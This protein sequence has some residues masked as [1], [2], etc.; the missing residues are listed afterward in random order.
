MEVLPA[1]ERIRQASADG[2]LAELCRSQGIELLVLFGSAVSSPTPG[3]IDLAV[4]FEPAG[5]GNLLD[6]V[7][8]LSE[9]FATDALD[10][11]D[12]D[13]AGPVARQRALT[14]GEILHQSSPRAF[15]ERHLWALA[16]YMET[17]G[18]RQLQ[19]EVLAGG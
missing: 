15:S 4:G 14:R 13:R 17:A 11:M 8:A 2:S 16:E 10:V 18:L 5:A 6:A 12:L 3:D 19:R 9:A 7:N 1:L